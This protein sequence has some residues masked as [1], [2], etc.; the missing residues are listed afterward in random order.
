MEEN[1]DG[2]MR[3]V[4]SES[5]QPRLGGLVSSCSQ[6]TRREN[7]QERRPLSVETLHGRGGKRDPS[8]S[9]EP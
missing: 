9:F 8:G 7:S 5:L 3:L 4:H 1:L 6:Y 2:I